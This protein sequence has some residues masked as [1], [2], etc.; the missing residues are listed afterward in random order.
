MSPQ[1]PVPRFGHG[2]R[3]QLNVLPCFASLSSKGL[4]FHW[5][6]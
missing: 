3:Y 5:S 4:S 2:G 6:P 1:I